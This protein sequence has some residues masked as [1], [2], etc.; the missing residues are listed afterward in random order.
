MPKNCLTCICV[1]INVLRP[2]QPTR[3]M[4]NVDSLPTCTFSWTGFVLVVVNQ[5]LCTFFHQKLTTA[6]LE[7]VKERKWLLKIF[8][9]QASWKNV[10][11]PGGDRICDLL[12]TSL[13][14]YLLNFLP[15]VLCV[16]MSPHLCFI[17]ELRLT[18]L[19]LNTTCPVLCY[20][21]TITIRGTTEIVVLIVD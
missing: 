3:A 10:T 11:G 19:M 6:L 2:S 5:Y 21:P 15:W 14:C 7:S 1:C 17:T 8:H 20:V 13:T 9:D 18:L 16:K 12:I 4:S